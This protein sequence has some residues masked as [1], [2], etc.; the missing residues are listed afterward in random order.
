VE[1]ASCVEHESVSREGSDE[2]PIPYLRQSSLSMAY[3]IHIHIHLQP[4]LLPILFPYSPRALSH[5]TVSLYRLIAFSLYYRYSS[6]KLWTWPCVPDALKF[7]AAEVVFVGM[8]GTSDTLKRSS[9][10][11]LIGQH[12]T[13]QTRILRGE[14]FAKKC[15]WRLKVLPRKYEPFEVTYRSLIYKVTSKV[16]QSPFFCSSLT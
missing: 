16:L 3:N 14:E 1:E 9:I 10:R 13:N 6:P 4:D 12:F 7:V 15:G 8:R 11:P 5:S 2:D